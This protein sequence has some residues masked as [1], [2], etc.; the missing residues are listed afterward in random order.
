MN[1][2]SWM[3]SLP[4]AVVG[5]IAQAVL[6]KKE[7]ALLN[8]E[9]EK[10]R[11]DIKNVRDHSDKADKAVYDTIERKNTEVHGRVDA[12][13][14]RIDSSSDKLLALDRDTLRTKEANIIYVTNKVMSLELKIRDNKADTIERDVL[15]ADSRLNELLCLEYKGDK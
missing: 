13:F 9:T 3:V 6:A 2:E 5:V 1:I 15:K 7:I 11:E 10:L 12:A 8:K 14:K 4:I